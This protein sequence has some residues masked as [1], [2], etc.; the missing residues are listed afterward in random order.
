MGLVAPMN[1]GVGG[2]LFALVYEARTGELWTQCVRGRRADRRLSPRQGIKQMQRGVN[3]VTVPG[4]GR[5]LGS[6]EADLLAPA[7]ATRAGI[8]GWRSR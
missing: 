6:A 2:D 7:I 1:D 8:P 3:S 4:A 5:G